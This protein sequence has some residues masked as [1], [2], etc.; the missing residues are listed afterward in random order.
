[1]NSNNPHLSAFGIYLSVMA[2]SN[3]I[4]ETLQVP[5]YTIWSEATAGEIIFAVVHCT[6][7]DILIAFAS[8]S[9]SFILLSSGRWPNER[10]WTVAGFTLAGGIIYTAYSEWV[11][12]QI[13]EAWTYSSS[14]PTLSTLE[15]GLSPL[16]QWA[17]LPSI[18]FIVVKRRLRF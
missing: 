17:I 7:G 18:S 16:L 14:M 5:L 1:M 9:I 8:L 2:F 13:K 6:V 4:W 11:N 15:I 12:T 10:F 3:L